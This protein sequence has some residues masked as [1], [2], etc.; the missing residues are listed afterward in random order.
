MARG[1]T[2]IAKGAIERAAS[3]LLAAAAANGVKGY[4]EVDLAAGLVTF[5]MS[6]KADAT[7]SLAPAE[8][9]SGNEW[10]TVK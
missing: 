3:G 1:K 5:H 7:A 6:E 9:D 2:L 10:D 8:S 4:L